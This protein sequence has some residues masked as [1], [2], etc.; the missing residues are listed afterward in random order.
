MQT[1]PEPATQ[2]R[3]PRGEKTS[4]P[5]EMASRLTHTITPSRTPPTRPAHPGSQML[6]SMQGHLQPDPGPFP[7]AVSL[8]AGETLPTPHP[9]IYAFK[10]YSLDV[11]GVY[12]EENSLPRS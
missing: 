11:W 12:L 5:K 4:I 9:F 10:Q 6:P 1:W 2:K 8:A 7:I 3:T